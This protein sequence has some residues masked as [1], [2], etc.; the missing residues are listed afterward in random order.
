MV[1]VP[2]II[3]PTYNAEKP[4][5]SIDRLFMRFI[6]D[7]RDLPFAYLCV[8]IS[9]TILPLSALLYT[10][11][12]TG[13]LWY[14]VATFR[15]LLGS[16]YFMG[17]YMLMLHNVC[18]RRYMR[19]GYEWMGGYIPYILGVLFGQTPD[20]YYTHHIGM[21]H[22]EN[23]LED[24]LS[25]TM[26]YKRDSIRHFAHYLGM[27]MVRG[28]LDLFFYF[29]TRNRKELAARI[30]RGETLYYIAAFILCYFAFKATVA[31]FLLP[32]V[33]VRFGMISG[34]WAQHAFIKADD[35]GN[36]WV[37]SITCINSV[38][39]ARCFNDGY[40]IGHHLRPHMHWTDMPLDFQKNLD[41]YAENECVIFQ[42][43][44]YFLIWIFLM[45][46]RYDKLA[47]YFVNVGNRFKSDEE[48]IHFL[49][50]RTQPIL[51]V[52]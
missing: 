25:T 39:N 14:L 4:L 27:F 38:Y 45:G 2:T 40:H 32:L 1:A 19:T 30:F 10:D 26:P 42:E 31:V 11:I 41:K 50:S 34:N 12:L 13:W 33:I 47:Q 15:I 5:N 6:H 24:D 44:D 46:K 7:Q 18:H 8:Q 36:S 16:L 17:P 28:P 20:T 37:N 3:D 35:P 21:H 49:K 48:V 51:Q 23:N 52:A 29:R 43:I 22:A 9:L